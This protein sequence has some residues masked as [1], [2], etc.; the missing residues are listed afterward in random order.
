MGETSRKCGRFHRQSR[1]CRGERKCW[2][3][4]K[5]LIQKKKTKE[6]RLGQDWIF[7]LLKGGKS[8]TQ[9]RTLAENTDDNLMCRHCKWCRCACSY[10]GLHSS[11]FWVPAVGNET[12]FSPHGSACPSCPAHECLRT[13]WTSTRKHRHTYRVWSLKACQCLKWWSKLYHH[14]LYVTQVMWLWMNVITIGFYKHNYLFKSCM[15]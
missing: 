5:R 10:S 12:P 3:C 2:K 1:R 13:R 9:W 6:N 7:T 14:A 8:L 15:N 11:W 4:R